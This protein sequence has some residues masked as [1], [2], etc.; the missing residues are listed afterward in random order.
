M[1]VRWSGFE[2]NLVR[3]HHLQFNGVFNGHDAL[4]IRDGAG[5]DVEKGRFSGAGIP[6]Y[7]DVQT[8]SDTNRHK[9][10]HPLSQSVFLDQILHRKLILQEPADGDTGALLRNGR[11][12]GIDA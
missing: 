10:C 4:M 6:R 7:H 1:I 8:R 12:D 11:N 9:I 3:L 2:R 5:E